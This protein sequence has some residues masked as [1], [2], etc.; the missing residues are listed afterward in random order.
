MTERDAELNAEMR[1]RA[2]RGCGR[3][4][5][6][7][8][9]VRQTATA[10]AAA[11]NTETSRL[12]EEV[13]RRENLVRA[14]ARVVQNGGAAGVDGMPVDDLMPSCRDHWARIRT[15]LLSGT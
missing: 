8:G 3:T 11:P 6:S 7:T 5:A 1:K 2:G 9:R 15:E 14:H 13:L 10:R 4:A 12:M